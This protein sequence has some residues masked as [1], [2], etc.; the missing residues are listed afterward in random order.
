[1]GR[2]GVSGAGAEDHSE[3]DTIPTCGNYYI[4]V[5]HVGYV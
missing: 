5:E 1:M 2:K 3:L 4:G